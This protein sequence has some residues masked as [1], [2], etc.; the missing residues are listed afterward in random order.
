MSTIAA[1]P[2]T[3]QTQ[4]IWL[5]WDSY[6]NWL[7]GKLRAAANA[8]GDRLELGGPWEPGKHMALIGIT[9]GGKTTH[10]VGILNL[11]KFVLALDPKGE[12][13][14]LAQ[15]GYVRVRD[16]PKKGIRT[17]TAKDQRTWRDIFKKVQAGQPARVVVGGAARSERQ[18]VALQS[19][20]REAITFCRYSGG[21]TLYVDEFELLSSQRMFRLGPA[22]ERMLITARRDGTSVLTAF[23]APAWVSRHATR[24][25]DWTVIWPSGDPDL[26]QTIARGMGRDWKDV[27]TANDQLPKWH[28]LTIPKSKM[29]GP[30]VITHA[31]KLVRQKPASSRDAGRP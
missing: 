19:L 9:G 24:Q 4:V 3:Q 8:S 22:V 16:L 7:G 10:A 11:R 13:E 5:P 6:L 27:A 28:T 1:E 31:P 14:T 26:I 29:G 12:D 2:P 25:A 21:W 23:Q 30:L 17:L 18:D 20:M 15:A